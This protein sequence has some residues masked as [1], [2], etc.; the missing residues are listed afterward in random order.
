MARIYGPRRDD[1]TAWDSKSVGSNGVPIETEQG[2]LLL[3]HGYD[4]DH[5]YRFGVVLLDLATCSFANLLAFA[6]GS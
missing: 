1:P 6:T 3:N 2:W 5:V 4:A